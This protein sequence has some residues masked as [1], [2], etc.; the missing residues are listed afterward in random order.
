MKHSWICE[1]TPLQA[2]LAN[3]DLR[4]ATLP[5]LHDGRKKYIWER[6]TTREVAPLVLRIAVAS[7]QG[8]FV[9][10]ALE[11]LPYTYHHKYRSP[12]WPAK[13]ALLGA[14]AFGSLPIVKMFNHRLVS[15]LDSLT[16]LYGSIAKWAPSGGRTP[17]A[18]PHRTSSR[19]G[20][21]IKLACRRYTNS[22][23]LAKAHKNWMTHNKPTGEMELQKVAPGI[24]QRPMPATSLP[25]LGI[26][27]DMEIPK[28]LSSS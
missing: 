22:A 9:K 15:P 7:G 13:P 10:W 6:D 18:T 5:S 3:E 19:V 4:L 21:P 12:T 2:A 28:W 16:S 25:G 27:H 8:D 24:L 1:T 23:V 26:P 11:H 20:S 17:L 14:A